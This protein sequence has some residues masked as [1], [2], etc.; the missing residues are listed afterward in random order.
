MEAIMRYLEHGFDGAVHL[1]P[2]YGAAGR[3]TDLFDK[4]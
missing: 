2:W 1:R 3:R 4:R